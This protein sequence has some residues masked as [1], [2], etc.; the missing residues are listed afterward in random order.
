MVTVA[1]DQ[2]Y[3]ADATVGNPFVTAIN[4]IVNVRCL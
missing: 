1:H 2:I 3:D 4:I